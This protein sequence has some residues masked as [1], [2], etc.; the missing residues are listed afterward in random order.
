[1]KHFKWLTK[2]KALTQ[3]YVV[4]TATWLCVLA[5]G[6]TPDTPVFAATQV[7]A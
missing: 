7:L 2:R 3:V 5:E 6:S 4:S 1:M